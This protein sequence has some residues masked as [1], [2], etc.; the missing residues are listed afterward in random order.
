MNKEIKNIETYIT[1]LETE[2]V[3]DGYNNGWL[4]KWYREKIIELKSRIKTLK[5]ND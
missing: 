2:L 5:E 1:K 4:N 3:M